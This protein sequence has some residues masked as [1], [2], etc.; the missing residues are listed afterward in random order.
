ME[1]GGLVSIVVITIFIILFASMGLRTVKKEII[2][3]EV[4]RNHESTPSELQI[5][6]GQEPFMFGVF[7][8]GFNLTTLPKM[9]DFAIV[10]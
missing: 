6:T 4:K 7:I 2:Q 5:T 8:Y 1:A 3:S 9:F 10:E